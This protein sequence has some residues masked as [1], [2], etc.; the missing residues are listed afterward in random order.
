V[1]FLFGFGWFL[2]LTSE[3]PS[4]VF[5]TRTDVFLSGKAE[6]A[7]ETRQISLLL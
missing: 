4:L 7:V 1:W 5:S 3:L 6:S 2:V